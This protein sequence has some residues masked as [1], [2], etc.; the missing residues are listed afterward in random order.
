M[1]VAEGNEHTPVTHTTVRNSN[2]TRTPV[3]VV[4]NL[5]PPSCTVLV[6][7]RFEGNGSDG[8]VGRVSVCT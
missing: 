4:R 7:F 1:L 5:F 2:D 3:N 6:L 8:V